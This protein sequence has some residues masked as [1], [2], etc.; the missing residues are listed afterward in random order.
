MILSFCCFLRQSPTRW[1]Q[2]S[3][4]ETKLICAVWRSAS[5]ESSPISPIGSTVP[6]LL[7]NVK[8]SPPVI[9]LLNEGKSSDFAKSQGIKEQSACCIFPESIRPM[10]RRRTLSKPSSFCNRL[11]PRPL[12]KP[13]RI[14]LF[15][16]PPVKTHFPKTAINFRLNP[17]SS[18]AFTMILLHE[19]SVRASHV[20]SRDIQS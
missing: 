7:M 4:G 5:S 8:E 19:T 15:I 6:A 3:I 14:I 13:V 2:K 16:M 20:I 1:L 18:S 12:E 10:A 17:R 11:F 9:I